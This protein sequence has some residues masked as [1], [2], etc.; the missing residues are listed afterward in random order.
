M[1]I[2]NLN[3]G[4][5][6]RT[7]KRGDVAN[8]ETG[9]VYAHDVLVPTSEIDSKE[10]LNG[11]ELFFLH[12]GNQ[13]SLVDYYDTVGLDIGVDIP[14]TWEQH[15]ARI[16]MSERPILKIDMEDDSNTLIDSLSELSTPQLPYIDEAPFYPPGQEP[17]DMD[18]QWVGKDERGPSK[19]RG[20]GKRKRKPRV[21]H[22]H[23]GKR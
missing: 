9:E 18:H 16:R 22:K 8:V 23:K 19:H 14:E 21:K 4:W 7:H 20:N 1:N 6:Y 15:C 10:L 17:K 2:N 3:G 11:A 5:Y 13:T 12:D